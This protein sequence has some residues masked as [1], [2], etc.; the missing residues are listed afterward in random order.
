MAFFNVRKMVVIPV[1]K[2][3]QVMFV[4]IVA[5]LII[6]VAM[7]RNSREIK[8]FPDV[9]PDAFQDG[10]LIFRKGTG[11][12]SDLFTKAGDSATPYSHVG[13]AYVDNGQVFVIHTEANELTGKGSAKIDKIEEF[14]GRE[15]SLYAAVYRLKDNSQ[16]YGK[17]A[18]EAA[19]GYAKQ[20]IPFDI[21]FDLTT[22]N[23]LYCTELVYLAYKNAGLNITDKLDIISYTV[24]SYQ[25][26][27]EIVSIRSILD[28]QIF[29]KVSDIV[30]N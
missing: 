25:Y 7:S 27:K 20:K 24:S 6:G 26:K 10:D 17:M 21:N 13:I 1:S 8:T 3:W 11:F 19:I 2:K 18:V 4:P 28:S 15:N 16:T 5:L 29:E 30:N 12:F 14:L 23:E 22:E 9:T